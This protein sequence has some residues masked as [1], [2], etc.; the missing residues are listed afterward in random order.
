MTNRVVFEPDAL[1]D[2]AVANQDAIDDL[3]AAQ[4]RYDVAMAPVHASGGTGQWTNVRAGFDDI[5]EE[6]AALAR[7]GEF[8]TWLAGRARELDAVSGGVA[9]L[10]QGDLR[11]ADM[12]SLWDA[13]MLYTRGTQVAGFM[14]GSVEGGPSAADLAMLELYADDPHFAEGLLYAFG[15]AAGLVDEFVRQHHQLAAEDAPGGIPLADGGPPE[16]LRA[17]TVALGTALG[18]ASLG[19][20]WEPSDT[21]DLAGIMTAIPGDPNYGPERAAGLAVLVAA[22]PHI[23]SEVV[24]RLLATAVEIDRT[25]GGPDAWAARANAPDTGVWPQPLVDHTGHP[26][27]DP[28]STLLL[29]AARHGD[30]ALAAFSTG[31][32]LPHVGADSVQR[33][34]DATLSHLLNGRNFDDQGWTRLGDALEAAVVPNVGIGDTGRAAAGVTGQ[35][36]A[37]LADRATGGNELPRQLHHA[38]ASLLTTAM[39]GAVPAI[40]GTDTTG[41][42]TSPQSWTLTTPP[43]Y[44]DGVAIQPMLHTHDVEVVLGRLGSSPREVERLTA[45]AVANIDLAITNELAQPNPDLDVIAAAAG[46]SADAAGTILANAYGGIVDDHAGNE[47]DRETMERIGAFVG[48]APGLGPAGTAIELGSDVIIYE[49][50]VPEDYRGAQPALLDMIS[51]RTLDDLFVQGWFDDTTIPADALRHHQGQAVGFDHTSTAF[52]EW[53]TSS[54][55]YPTTAL[56]NVVRR[57]LWSSDRYGGES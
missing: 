20:D 30:A 48:A 17:L 8:T 15:G 54:P 56:T 32:T 27:R 46:T 57:G 52:L 44:P 9:R 19:P 5:D 43:I 14:K 31:G 51:Q 7:L 6:V 10:E 42:A 2:Y 34:V 35:T 12:A 28:V 39:P 40:A 50:A 25:Q 49:Y 36:M 29:A 55:D 4:G 1:D 26:A 47:A 13:E 23:S 33:R 45:V 18:R 22:A 16:Q 11:A 53:Q 24:A 38:T 37:L 3:R 41:W 21:D